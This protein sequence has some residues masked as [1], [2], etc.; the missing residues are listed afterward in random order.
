MSLYSSNLSPLQPGEFTQPYKHAA[1]LF[2]ADTFKLAP[3]HSFLYYVVF[4]IDS[5]QT[6]LGNG[7]L[8]NVLEFSS[9]YEKLSNGMLIKDIELPKFSIGVKTLNAYNRKNIVQTNIS[10]DPINVTFHDDAANTITNFWNDY[11][12]Y[13]FRDSDYTVSS[14]GV[15]EKYDRRRLNGWGFSPRNGALNTFLRGIRIFSLHRRS[16]E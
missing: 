12:T 13:Y 1:K 9:R 10:Y 14:Y 6:E 2:V 5:S 11:Y 16:V 15:P 8:N 7:V 4:D 3:K